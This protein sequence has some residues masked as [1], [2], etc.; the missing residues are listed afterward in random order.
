MSL[1]YSSVPT[2]TLATSLNSSGMVLRVS[3]IKGWNG[4]DLTASD[5]G[6]IAYIVLRN[7]T[8]TAIEIIEID[9]TTIASRNITINKRGLKF[10]G[11]RTTEVAANKL[12]WVQGSTSVDL[13]ASTP[14]M[15]QTL[16]ENFEAAIIAGGVPAT[17]SVLGLNRM[18]AAPV[19]PAVPIALGENDGRVPT[20]DEKAILVAIE[21]GTYFP[22]P[23]VVTFT[24]SGTW[25][26]DAGLKYVVVE[27][28]GGGAGGN[29]GGDTGSGISPCGAGGAAGGYSRKL[30]LA[31]ALGATETVTTGG[32]GSAGAGNNGVAT[33]GATSSFG[34]HASATG[35]GIVGGNSIVSGLGGIGSNGDV[36]VSGGSGES[37]SN[38]GQA[39]ATGGN[40]MLGGGGRGVPNAS[41]AVGGLYGG[42]GGGGDSTSS[43]G[44]PGGAG[45]GGIVIVTEYY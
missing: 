10:E 20:A 4:L 31:A 16:Q 26:K 9:A 25:T 41:G 42:G 40:S 43:N 3:D 44:T 39:G 34:A 21:A 22:T 37:G 35:G 36:N 5:F 28:Q 7:A 27:V 2:K 17:T 13:G 24:S 23:Q 38:P 30:I 45:A 12:A 33:A 29:G 11:D 19:D 14:Q 1:K 15:L 8:N 32:G 18:S 6:T